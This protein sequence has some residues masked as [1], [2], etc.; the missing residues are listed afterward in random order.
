LAVLVAAA[1]PVDF[2]G[3]SEFDY[4]I[5]TGSGRYDACLAQIRQN[6]DKGF[7]EALIWRDQGGG[8]PARHC[9]ALAL[10]ALGH[11]GEAARRLDEI[12]RDPGAGGKDIRAQILSQAGNAWLLEGEVAR[13]I[14]AFGAGL[15]VADESPRLRF[16]LLFDRARAH[17]IAHDWLAAIEDATEIVTARPRATDA[18]VLRARA[19]RGQGAVSSALRDAEAAVALDPGDAEAVFE[20]GAARLLKGETGV[21]REDFVRVLRLAPDESAIAEA[22]RAALE[23]I[24]I[25]SAE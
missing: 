7:D 15:G 11:T 6:P 4:G 21:A 22:A 19:Y 25:G 13:A 9:A 16:E 23:R 2:A 14:E 12:A 8:V 24:E 20:R 10:F 17:L 18:L 5:V 1:L 3:A